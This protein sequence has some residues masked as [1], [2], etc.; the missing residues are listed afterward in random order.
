[1][2]KLIYLAIPC[3]YNPAES[4]DAANSKTHAQKVRVIFSKNESYV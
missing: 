2:K 1:M 3:C 4:F